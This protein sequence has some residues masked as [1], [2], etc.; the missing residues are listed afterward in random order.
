MCVLLPKRNFGFAHLLIEME[1]QGDF[2]KEVVLEDEHGVQLI[3]KVMY[4]WRP[5]HCTTC[6][7]DGHTSTVC[8]NAKKKKV[9]QVWRPKVVS[10]PFTNTTVEPV[11]VAPSTMEV[12]SG[13]GQQT[14]QSDSQV[15]KELDSQQVAVQGMAKG[16][17][18]KG[19]HA[20]LDSAAMPFTSMAARRKQVGR[21]PSRLSC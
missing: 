21:P 19:V 5:I 18:I 3:Q 1:I 17:I 7:G 13:E 15:C 14:E 6:K 10:K 2:P 20:V 9:V 4:E 12:I 16:T 11:V 8:P